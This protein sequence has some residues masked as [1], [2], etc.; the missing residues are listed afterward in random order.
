MKKRSKSLIISDLLSIWRFRRIRK[1]ASAKSTLP[2]QREPHSLN[3]EI[4]YF[5][6]SLRLVSRLLGAENVKNTLSPANII[7]DKARS[8]VAASFLS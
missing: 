3:V 5:Q 6:Q 2:L 7:G 4:Y 1:R 8:R